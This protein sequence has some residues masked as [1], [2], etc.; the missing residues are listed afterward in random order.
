METYETKGYWDATVYEDQISGTGHELF[1]RVAGH[2]P[3]APV[4]NDFFDVVRATGFDKMDSLYA[5]FQQRYPE[6]SV[7]ESVLNT[8]GLQLGL[9][10]DESKGLLK[11]KL[12]FYSLGDI[13]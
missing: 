2:P 6:F 10:R 11:N 12:T 13:E 8:V 9:S 3:P 4:I 5:N 1:K 7:P